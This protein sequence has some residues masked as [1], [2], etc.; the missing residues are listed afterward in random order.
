MKQRR[1]RHCPKYCDKIGC[2]ETYEERKILE[3]PFKAVNM[4]CAMGQLLC[5]TP[6]DKNKWD[7]RMLGTINGINFPDDWDTLTEEEKTR[8]LE[9]AKE[10]IA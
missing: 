6:E 5:D 4:I 1:S 10:Q 8:R 2:Y 7:R 9:G 3:S